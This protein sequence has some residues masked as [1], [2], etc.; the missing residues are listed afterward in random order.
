MAI[1]VELQKTGTHLRSFAFAITPV[2][3]IPGDGGEGVM[4]DCWWVRLIRRNRHQG[5]GHRHIHRLIGHGHGH[6]FGGIAGAVGAA[7]AVLV[8]TAIGTGLWRPAPHPSQPYSGSGLGPEELNGVPVPFIGGPE[9]MG[10]GVGSELAALAVPSI[11]NGSGAGETNQIGNL[12]GQPGSIETSAAPAVAVIGQVPEPSSALML[13]ETALAMA[14]LRAPRSRRAAAGDSRS[15]S[16][17][18]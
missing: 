9:S 14:L 2:P 1:Y 5:H 3:E 16:R 10:A 6:V 11:G 15:R 18:C 7:T 17:R 12:S 13:T 8:C 4:I